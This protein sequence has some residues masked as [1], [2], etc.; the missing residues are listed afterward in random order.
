MEEGV[1]GLAVRVTAPLLLTQA[2]RDKGRE[3][4]ASLRT[5]AMIYVRGAVITNESLCRVEEVRRAKKG[6]CAAGSGEGRFG[7][8]LLLDTA[9][10]AAVASFL[11]F[12]PVMV[13]CAQV[14]S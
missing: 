8:L 12:Q 11:P 9:T 7:T 14:A 4:L 13:T 10:C 5:A 6:S 2:V 3:Q 1:Y